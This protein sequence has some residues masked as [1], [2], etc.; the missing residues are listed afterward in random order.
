MDRRRILLGA[1]GA[2][3]AIAGCTSTI[4]HGDDGTDADG[5]VSP[6]DGTDGQQSEEDTE[7]LQERIEDLETEIVQLEA[8]LRE[9]RHTESEDLKAVRRDELAT[10][11][12]ELYA[13]AQERY[14]SAEEYL[15]KADE[16]FSNRDWAFAGSTYVDAAMRYQAGHYFAGQVLS[17]VGASDVRVVTPSPGELGDPINYC[18]HM[19][20]HAARM[21]NQSA[22]NR[23]LEELSDYPLETRKESQHSD[24]AEDY[25]WMPLEEFEA[26]VSVDVEG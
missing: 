10:Q 6:G 7:D 23:R 19:S 24:L 16:E 22:A 4:N 21:A 25:R 9:E 11:V 14:E 8:E 5:N 2:A 12:I 18:I 17:A 20:N 15:A 13:F 3:V 26:G 1:A